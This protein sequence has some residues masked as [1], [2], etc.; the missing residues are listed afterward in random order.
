MSGTLDGLSAD[1]GGA[2]SGQP[3]GNSAPVSSDKV[4]PPQAFP[5]SVTETRR[6]LAS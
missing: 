2:G 4:Q 6:G 1:R 3:M 5:I